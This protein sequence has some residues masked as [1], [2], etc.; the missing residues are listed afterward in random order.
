MSILLLILSLHVYV[1]IKNTNN[2]YS[3]NS[4]D[5]ACLINQV[6][7]PVTLWKTPINLNFFIQSDKGT[8]NDLFSKNKSFS[9]YQKI[10]PRV[11][12]KY[13]NTYSNKGKSNLQTILKPT[14]T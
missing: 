9:G 3:S 6:Q 14:E 5:D 1:L 12:P 11:S 8:T 13:P 2:F 7:I 4:G 10:K